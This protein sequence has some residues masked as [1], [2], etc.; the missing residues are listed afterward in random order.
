MKVSA[1]RSVARISWRVRPGTRRA[2]HRRAL[3]ILRTDLL[4]EDLAGDGRGKAAG[5]GVDLG[6]GG[7]L[8]R[9]DVALGA[10]A[11]GVDFGI[12][13]G[14][15]ICGDGLLL[16][17]GVVEHLLGLG[18]CLGEALLVLLE[19]FLGLLLGQFGGL[20][21]FLDLRGPLIKGGGDGRPHLGRENG[22]DQQEHDYAGDAG[23]QALLDRWQRADGF[24][25]R[26]EGERSGQS[27]EGGNG[28]G[29][30][31]AHLG[32]PSQTVKDRGKPGAALS[33][34]PG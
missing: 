2:T 5:L 7:A 3:L 13:L 10:F 31:R 12:G 26:G 6:E 20:D 32:S 4:L 17:L 34:G 29:E 33:R 15:E 1:P 14:L 28:N 16:G 11:H 19:G 22:K 18:A 27:Q 8:G 25:G 21:L 23:G 30:Q 24:V 9:V